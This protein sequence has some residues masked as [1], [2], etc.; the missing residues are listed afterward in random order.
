M[1]LHGIT[2]ELGDLKAW[3]QQYG[4]SGKYDQLLEKTLNYWKKITSAVAIVTGDSDFDN[5][6][7]WISYQI[8]CRQIFGNSYLPDFGY[9]RGGRGWRDLWQDLLSIFLVDPDSA[10]EEM[11]NSLKGIRVDGSNATIIGTRPGSFVADRNNVPRTWS[12]HGAWPAFVI[13]FY[14]NQTGDLD[15]LFRDIPYWKD[16]FSHRSRKTDKKYSPGSGNW[17]QTISGEEYSASIFEHLLVQ[18]LSAFYNVGDHNVLL[19]EGADWNDTYDM[20]RE[21]GESIGFYAFYARNLRILAGWLEAI[22]KKGIEYIP[23]LK[24]IEILINT[25]GHSHSYSA[26]EKQEQLHRYFDAVAHKVSGEKAMV[27][28]QSLILDLVLK[29]EHI[30]NLLREQEW[31][32]LDESKGFFNGHYDNLGRA[33][34]GEKKGKVMI[35]LTTQVMATMHQLATRNQVRQIINSADRYLK[36]G[37]GYR[38]CTPFSEID[39]NIGRLTG[40]VYGHKEHGS[41]WMQQNIMLA[42]G[43]YI[44]GFDSIANDI[45]Q[46]A[47]KLSTDSARSKIFPGMPSYFGPG[48]RGAYAYLTG[49]STWYLLTLTTRVFGIRGLMGD[50]CLQ[51]QLRPTQFNSEGRASIVCTFRGIMLRVTYQFDRAYPGSAYTIE[52]IS[53]NGK[54]PNTQIR[55][56]HLHVIGM[57]ELEHLCQEGT[58]EILVTL[59]VNE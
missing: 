22:A 43:L 42:Y 15:I 52:S 49:S 40:F 45:I 56:S 51:P 11:V 57:H 48:D 6:T 30:D 10:R 32:T 47:F 55:E 9:G 20:A 25:N 8:K 33:V 18:Q 28:I 12:D 29:A 39:M 3:K 37:R 21:K 58:N 41:K 24:E 5:W 4:T 35:D 34:D 59:K 2:E 13:D 26:R 53:I 44:Q 36:D 31:I 38:L 19:L 54:E 50:L 1:I 16:Q 17:Q 46:D 14:I 23:L 27:G 7:R